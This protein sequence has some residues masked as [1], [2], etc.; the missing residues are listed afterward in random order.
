MTCACNLSSQ[1]VEVGESQ[2]E[3]SRDYTTIE[4]QDSL[5]YIVRI[6]PLNMQKLLLKVNVDCNTRALCV[7]EKSDQPMASVLCRWLWK[8]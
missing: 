7:L 3:T 1:E 8:W 4:F 5:S 2:L 6:C